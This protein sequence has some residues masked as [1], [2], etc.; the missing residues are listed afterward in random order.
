MTWTYDPTKLT[1]A[2]FGTLMQVR[3]MVEDTISTDPQLQD[4][5]INWLVTQE[6]STY[7]AAARAAETIAARYARQVDRSVGAMKLSASQRFKTYSELSSA[8]RAKA[9]MM[10]SPYAGGISQADKQTNEQDTDRVAP[11]FG[12]GM[13]RNPGA[14]NASGLT[15]EDGD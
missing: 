9:R 2:T 7:L 6:G 11:A 1:D 10:V 14:P 8:L 4:E 5:E 12:S 13:M 15:D 3:L